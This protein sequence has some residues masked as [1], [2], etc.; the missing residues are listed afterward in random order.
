MS[1]IGTRTPFP[2]SKEEV[3]DEEG[4]YIYSHNALRLNGETLNFVLRLI[5]K[6]F[7]CIFVTTWEPS[8]PTSVI[9]S[10]CLLWCCGH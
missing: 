2:S 8:Y 5:I 10:N 1:N 7:I 6:E 3:E 9:T 4:H